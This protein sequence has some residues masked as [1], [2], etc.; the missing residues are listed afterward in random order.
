M[1]N[2]ALSD[3]LVDD[4]EREDLCASIINNRARLSTLAVA[5]L[6]KIALLDILIISRS[7]QV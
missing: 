5:E 6:K 2:G 3:D 4:D 7:L 1:G